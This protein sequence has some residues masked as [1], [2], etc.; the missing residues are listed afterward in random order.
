[1]L[2]IHKKYIDRLTNEWEQ[3]GKIIIALDFDDTI[4]PWGFKDDNSSKGFEEIAYLLKECKK[5]GC[6]IS[7][8]SACAPERYDEIKVHCAK[9]GIEIDSINQNPIDLPYGNHRKMYYNIL[10]DDR[11]GLQDAIDILTAAL[12]NIKGKQNTNAVMAQI[13]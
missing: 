7:I 13:Y 4:F 8:W 2:G 3:Y 5:L 10:L 11:A 6:Y 1:M 9:L 12:Y